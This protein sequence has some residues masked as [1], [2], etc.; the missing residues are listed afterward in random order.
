MTTLTQPMRYP[1]TCPACTYKWQG[2]V[3]KP[4]KCPSCQAKLNYPKPSPSR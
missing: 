2:L 1:Q 4:K 3:A